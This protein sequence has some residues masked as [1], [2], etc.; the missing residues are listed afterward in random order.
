LN[1]KTI[2][3]FFIYINISSYRFNIKYAKKSDTIWDKTEIVDDKKN[4]ILEIF[5]NNIES[6]NVKVLTSK[7]SN[8]ED[9]KLYFHTKNYNEVL[10]YKFI[11]YKKSCL[12]LKNEIWYNNDNFDKFNFWDWE[13]KV[14]Y[15]NELSKYSRDEDCKYVIWKNTYR[16]NTK[17]DPET[18]YK[19]KIEKQLLDNN[20]YPLASEYNT[21]IKTGLALNEDKWVWKVDTRDLILV[22][23]DISPLWV[24]IQTVNLDKVEVTV[25]EWSFDILQGDYMK[26]KLCE[27]KQVWINNLWFKTNFSVLNLEE[28]YWRNFSKS[29]I[30]YNVGKIRKDK[31]KY[32]LKN[33]SDSRYNRSTRYIRTDKSLV[34]KSNTSNLL[35]LSDFKT[36]E[37]LSDQIQKIERYEKKSKYSMFGKYVWQE[38][39]F[40]NFVKSESLWKWMYKLSG[41]LVWYLLVTLN[42]W[43]KILL[44][45]TWARYD[46]PNQKVF[47]TTDR[48]IYKPWNKVRIKWV[49]RKETA[50]EYQVYKWEYDLKIKS[51]PPKISKKETSKDTETNTWDYD[52]VIRDS[53]YK[54]IINKK[55]SLSEN[56]T[57]DLEF[58]LEKEASLWN[59]NINY[60]NNSVSFAVEEFEKPDFKVESKSEKE[61]YLYTETPVVWINADYYIGSPL[62][63][64]SWY[65]WINA[66]EYNFDGWKTTWYNW[67]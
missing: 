28:I 26:N 55:V 58:D 7:I 65:Y 48:P 62:A 5:D 10:E 14:N 30:S 31:T 1:R 43:E 9:E 24:A 17:L 61:F 56:W 20:N 18:S 13:I 52:L 41:D 60:L 47:L 45:A 42:T 59:Y 15:I 23:T 51:T 57:F 34:L 38:S 63:N 25:C 46:S 50:T 44:N 39:V 36:W 27:T 3:C 40:K 33:D 19:L 35:W 16:V 49:V 66:S 22:P 32:E 29:I 11:N 67:W 6:L 53:R 21:G 4:I 64:G 54:E 8:S 37:L 2:W 12:V